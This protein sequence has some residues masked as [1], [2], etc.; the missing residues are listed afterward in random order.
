MQCN[1]GKIDKIIRITL[2]VILVSIAVLFIQGW[3]FI[4]LLLIFSGAFAYCPL[5]KLFNFSTG[6][7][8]SE[9]SS[10]DTKES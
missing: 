4:G 5:Y 3:A 6:C 1:V 7:A 8:N 2:G 10:S 9:A